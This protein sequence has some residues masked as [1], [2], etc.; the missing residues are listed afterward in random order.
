MELRPIYVLGFVIATTFALLLLLRIGQSLFSG[1]KAGDKM[2]KPNAARRMLFVGEVLAVFLISAAVVHNCVTGTLMHDALW[3]SAMAF[4]GLVLL[5]AS[6]RAGMMLL[7]DSRLAA[8]IE[9]GNVAAG[10]AAGAHYVATGI[11]TARAMAGN[12]L[13]SLGL[14]LVFFVLAQ[15]TLHVFVSLFR[16][17]TV[18]DD[19]EQIRGENLAA[20]ISY[21]G[22]AIAI[23]I[24]IARALEGDFVSWPVSLKAYGFALLFALALWPVRQ[25]L[26]QSV[27]LGFPFKMRGGRL[28]EDI[29]KERNEAM[30]VLEAVTYLATALSIARLA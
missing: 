2:T 10:V 17:L 13:P 26:V 9:R 6:G 21:G 3:V 29:A 18:Y 7:L 1:E 23:S 28:D 12:D 22:V 19:A 27:L 25:I 15:V 8:E 24:L 4:I 14:S 20:A 5:V 30:G 11:I 16:A